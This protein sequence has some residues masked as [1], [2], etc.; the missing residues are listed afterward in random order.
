MLLIL[1]ISQTSFFTIPRQFP[2]TLKGVT[3]SSSLQVSD[4]FDTT[5]C[6]QIIF[7][8]KEGFGY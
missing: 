4:M 7:S 2:V 8:L 3:H 5:A 6:L 1:Q